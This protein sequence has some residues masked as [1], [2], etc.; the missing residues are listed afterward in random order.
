MRFL[1]KSITEI[2]PI[3]GTSP[4]FLVYLAMQLE[5]CCQPVIADQGKCQLCSDGTENYQRTIY[6]LSQLT[7]LNQNLDFL[8]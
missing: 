6:T 1:M 3:A 5:N 8:V 4:T 7:F 2:K